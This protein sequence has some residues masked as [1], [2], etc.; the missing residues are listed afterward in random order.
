MPAGDG[1]LIAGVVGDAVV[2]KLR[3]LGSALRVVVSQLGE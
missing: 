1:A 3:P 2:I